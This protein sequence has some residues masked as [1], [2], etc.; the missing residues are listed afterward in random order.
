MAKKTE[1]PPSWKQRKACIKRRWTLP[2]QRIEWACEWFSYRMS[3]WAFIEVLEYAGKLAVLVTAISYVFGGQQRKQIAEDARKSRHYVAWQ[4]LNSAYGKPGNAGREDA[5][6]ELNRDGVSLNA[7]N[8]GGGA[9]FS[10]SLILTNAE[11]MF[12]VFPDAAFEF[13]NFKRANIA[14]SAFLRST[15]LGGIFKKTDLSDSSMFMAEFYM[16]DFQEAKLFNS[17]L[18]N[19][20]LKYCNFVGA[21]MDIAPGSSN[22]FRYCNMANAEMYQWYNFLKDKNPFETLEGCNVFGLK[23]PAEFLDWATNEG[24]AVSVPITKYNEWLNCIM[25]NKSGFDFF[26]ELNFFKATNVLTLGSHD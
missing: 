1:A 2:F 21:N 24:G 4:T 6:V 5:L 9:R 15:C 26:E 13:P 18:T 25:T 12:A 3:Q 20:A 16:C 23:A 10:A 7:V 19:T 14:S 8:L 17:H 22:S 11:M